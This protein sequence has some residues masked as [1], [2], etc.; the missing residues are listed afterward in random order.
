MVN[1]AAVSLMNV[2]LNPET[3]PIFLIVNVFSERVILTSG[4]L[5]TGIFEELKEIESQRMHEGAQHA[6]GEVKNVTNDHDEDEEYPI[7][8][9]ITQGESANG[10]EGFT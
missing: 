8:T 1:E 2:S 4:A 9:T 5:V 7:H 3:S 6:H 10:I